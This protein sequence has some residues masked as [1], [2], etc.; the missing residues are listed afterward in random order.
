MDPVTGSAT[1]L[2]HGVCIHQPVGGYAHVALPPSTIESNIFT[3]GRHYWSAR[4][5]C[6]KIYAG[7]PPCLSMSLRLLSRDVMVKASWEL[8][9]IDPLRGSLPPAP[10]YATGLYYFVSSEL[11]WD[12]DYVYVSDRCLSYV[13]DHGSLVLQITVKIFNSPTTIRRQQ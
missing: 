7:N 6:H 1:V 3:A 5:I 12:L 4:F 2:Y 9:V 13:D 10:L 11:R 8:S